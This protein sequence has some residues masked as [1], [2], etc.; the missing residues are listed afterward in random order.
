MTFFLDQ[1]PLP[2]PPNDLPGD[3]DPGL[4]DGLG[5]AWTAEAIETDAWHRQNQATL[6]VLEEIEAQIPTPLRVEDTR[7][8]KVQARHGGLSDDRIDRALEGAGL[9]AARDPGAWGN[10]PLDRDQLEAEVNRR[11]QA[12]WEDAMQTLGLLGWGRGLVEFTGRGA[13]AMT[14]EVSLLTAPLGGPGKSILGTVVRGGVAGG[15]AESMILPKMYEVSDRLDVPEPNPLAQLGMGIAFGGALAGIFDG[16]ARYLQ[17]LRGRKLQ[18]DDVPAGS[19]AIEAEAQVTAVERA[20]EDGAPISAVAGGV[21][22][23]NL[24]KDITAAIDAGEAGGDYRALFNF[25]NRSGGP[26]GGIDVTTMTIDELLAFADPRGAYGQYV[27]RNNPRGEVATPMGRYQIVGST[28]RRLKNRLG[29]TGTE[30]FDRAMQDRLGRVLMA[31]AGLDLHLSGAMSRADLDRNLRGVWAGYRAGA[32]GAAGNVDAPYIPTR[33]GY[34]LPDQVGTGTGRRVDV[35]YEVV[36]AS[37]LQRAT[38][39]LQ[40]RDRGRVTSDEQIAEIAARLDPARL[41]PTAEA[42]RGAPIVGPDNIIESGNGRV[43]AI[44]RANELYPDR[45]QAYRNA[46]EAAGFDVPEGV[47]APVLVARRTSDLSDADR[48]AFAR[49]ANASEISR[50]SATEQA[51]VDAAALTPDALS[52]YRPD[53]DLF[54][55][56]NDTFVRQVLRGI[57]RNE[58]AALIGRSGRLNVDGQRRVRQAL[59]ARAFGDT[60]LLEIIA[61]TGDRT[62]SG[63]LQA[64]EDAAPSWAQLR[65]A[66]DAGDVSPDLDAVPHLVDAVDLISKARGEAGGTVRARIDDAL[67]SPDLIDGALDPAVAAFVEIFYNGPR[68]RNAS[69]VAEILKAYASEALIIRGGP[70]LFGDALSV[71]PREILNAANRERDIFAGAAPDTG[72]RNDGS[73][74]GQ[75][76][77]GADGGGPEVGQLE[78]DPRIFDPEPFQDGA[79]SEGAQRAADELEAE[80]RSDIPSESARGGGSDGASPADGEF[81]ARDLAPG[82]IDDLEV[83][84][85]AGNVIR[86][87]DLLDD[88]ENEDAAVQVIEACNPKG[89]A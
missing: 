79:A 89:G 28:L 16:G 70:D 2:E 13:R 32:R 64:L 56:E 77:Q 74:G 71:G 80:L 23:V 1:S 36:D 35:S 73:W 33:A 22:E 14:D 75:L 8:P 57:P 20:L 62:M 29:L 18:D 11:Q 37:L 26:F 54:S 21:A 63:I 65:A 39:D 66:I 19:D 84:D 81:A 43:Q 38:G 46:I 25:S 47:D 52:L 50:M 7:P 78:L 27:K 9:A 15:A 68:A 76:G 59:F 86:A 83:E 10:L 45:A 34:T 55:P 67:G 51:R 72:P 4:V 44:V 17:Y 6:D 5:A 49:E 48:A 41:M 24:V 30:V 3:Q 61:E 31:D 85:A 82:S 40:P 60:R 69:D 42:D 87:R 12:E 53:R 58:R 88:L